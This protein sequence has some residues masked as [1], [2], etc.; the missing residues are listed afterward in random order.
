MRRRSRRSST[1]ICSACDVA[2]FGVGVGVGFG[3]GFGVGVGVGV[4]FGFGFG[5][6]FGVSFRY[7]FGTNL[8]PHGHAPPRVTP[9][10]AA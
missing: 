2:R 4:G 7:G 3:V 10:C 9:H 1:R 5:F 8:K 6:G